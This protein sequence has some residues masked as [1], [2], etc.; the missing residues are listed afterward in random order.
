MQIYRFIN[1]IFTFSILIKISSIVKG[2][3]FN[4]I[5]TELRFDFKFLNILYIWC[6]CTII[7]PNLLS[8]NSFYGEFKTLYKQEKGKSL[9]LLIS[10]CDHYINR[11]EA[12]N[13]SSC[14]TA[15]ENLLWLLMETDLI[16]AQF[17]RDLSIW[18]QSG[19]EVLSGSIWQHF[20]CQGQD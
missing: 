9:R 10:T 13:V 14:P 11:P 20:N 3:Y 19:H 12:R 2:R 4:L 18:A 6:C 7:D 5:L 17:H 1:Y 15:K 8:S 16:R